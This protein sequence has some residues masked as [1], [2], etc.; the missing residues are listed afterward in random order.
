MVKKVV[1][2]HTGA[3][4][5]Y[6]L[7]LAF[8]E[9]YLLEKLV[10]D[11]YF[12]KPRAFFGLV[13]TIRSKSELSLA[14][15]NSNWVLGLD[16]IR[17]KIFKGSN[18]SRL[19]DSILSNKALNIAIN[20]N[21]NLFLYSYYA[22]EAFFNASRFGFD[23]SKILFQLHPHPSSIRNILGNEVERYPFCLQSINSELEFHLSEMDLYKLKNESV[24][25]DYV[26][27]ASSFTKNT[28]MENGINSNKIFVVPYGVNHSMFPYVKKHNTKG[29]FTILF[30]GQMVQ[31]KGL[32]DLLYS[33]EL[34]KSSNL[35]VI[36]CGRGNI[37]I[38]I[39]NHFSHLD[40]DIRHNVSN[41]ELLE[42]VKEVNL[43]V[44]P[45]LVE[46]FGHVILEAMSM[47]LVP[48]TTSNTCGPDVITDE[49]N[50]FIVK[51]KDPH[52]LATLID[53]KISRI[54][55]LNEMG[56]LASIRANEFSWEKFRNSIIFNYLS[57]YE[58]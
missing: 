8:N 7:S 58:D 14:R 48:I 17:K 10:T 44:M 46:G 15:V 21:S 34:L 12:K 40:L 45:S 22:Y 52:E 19:V 36:I 1:T 4:D 32:A 41:F 18:H 57:L 33:V 56:H 2:A 43:F 47:G 28:L 54:N 51:P 55:D 3:R 13:N 30:M 49:L 37:D 6:Q 50:G 11:L 5:D 42:I 16:L 24:I 20:S 26:F 38:G 23:G 31:R 39:L 29:K 53:S 9:V 35:K 25:A 27:V